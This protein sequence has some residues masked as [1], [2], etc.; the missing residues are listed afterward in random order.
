M[1]AR[2]ALL[3]AL[4]LPL[5]LLLWSIGGHVHLRGVTLA[6]PACPHG[7]LIDALEHG[8]PPDAPTDHADLDHRHCHC[9]LLGIP[10]PNLRVVL[11]V[12]PMTQPGATAPPCL[13]GPPARPERPQWSGLA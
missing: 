1:R 8:H 6:D 11:G 12:A 10:V 7:A 3:L 5:Q 13:E 2:L 4:Y 9:Q